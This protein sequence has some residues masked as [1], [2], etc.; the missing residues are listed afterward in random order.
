[1]ILILWFL[2]TGTL[3]RRATRLMTFDKNIIARRSR[4]EIRRNFISQR[5]V[6]KW[7]ELPII[8]KNSRSLAT[9]KHRFDNNLVITGASAAENIN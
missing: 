5:V 7:N 3:D 2:T 6:N 8:V 1:M 9:F 4:L